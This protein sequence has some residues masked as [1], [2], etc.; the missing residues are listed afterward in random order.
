MVKEKQ[1]KVKLPKHVLVIGGGDVAMDV[2]STLK[3]LN[4]PHVTDVVY[5]TLD[6]FRASK[7]ELQTARDLKVSIYDGYIPTMVKNSTVTFKH[8]YLKSEISIQADLIILAV[9]QG[10]ML[11][12][13]NLKLTK[14]KEN[15]SEIYV[16]KDKNVYVTGDLA[17]PFYKTVVGAVRYGKD[18][19]RLVNK[20]LRGK[21]H[22]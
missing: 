13:L 7:K 11:D 4:V 8:R 12:G 18:V 2:T 10:P 16:A 5:E 1:G 22:D 6:E 17:N 14:S 15:G 20:T 9:G 21:N 3:L 19:A